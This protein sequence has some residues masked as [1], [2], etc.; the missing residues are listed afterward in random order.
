MSADSNT[1][2]AGASCDDDKGD[3]SSCVR[4]LMFKHAILNTTW[5]VCKPVR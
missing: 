5:P 3:R 4:I 1:M 2:D